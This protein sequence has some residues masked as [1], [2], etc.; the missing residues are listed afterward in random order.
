MGLFSLSILFSLVVA[1]GEP[2]QKVA[3]TPVRFASKENSIQ[4]DKKGITFNGTF[5]PFGRERIVEVTT[6]NCSDPLSDGDRVKYHAV[7]RFAVNTG[8]EIIFVELH[9]SRRRGLVPSWAT[10]L[11]GYSSPSHITQGV[12][13][14]ERHDVL[15]VHVVSVDNH[16][17]FFDIS[18]E[19]LRSP[20][21][22]QQQILESRAFRA[23]R[24]QARDVLFSES[25]SDEYGIRRNRD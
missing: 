24:T 23:R 8:K 21:F 13:S 9:R 3:A 19:N 10:G 2:T 12:V 6:G 18:D 15:G 16:D 25:I 4:L 14:F 11:R 17:L 5:F 20:S 22:F 1:K 7:T